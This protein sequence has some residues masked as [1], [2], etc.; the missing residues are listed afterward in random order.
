MSTAKDSLVRRSKLKLPYPSAQFSHR[1][2]QSHSPWLKLFRDNLPFQMSTHENIQMNQ[3]IDKI[4]HRNLKINSIKLLKVLQK[5]LRVALFV[6]EISSI[7]AKKNFF[8]RLIEGVACTVFKIKVQI[9]LTFQF[10]S[11]NFADLK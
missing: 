4:V 2:N 1:R 8:N 10:A 7:E 6:I 11:Y 9:G 3:Q 5:Y